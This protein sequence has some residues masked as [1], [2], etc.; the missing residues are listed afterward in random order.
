M[1][2]KALPILT[3][4]YEFVNNCKFVQIKPTLLYIKVTNQFEALVSITT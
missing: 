3:V 4:I 1:I 2:Y